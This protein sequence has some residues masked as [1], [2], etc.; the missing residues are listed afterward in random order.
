MVTPR[1]NVG[2][3][4]GNFEAKS[5]FSGEC[6]CLPASADVETGLMHVRI[7]LLISHCERGLHV[8]RPSNEGP[9]RGLFVD[10]G[11]PRVRSSTTLPFFPLDVIGSEFNLP[12]GQVRSHVII[13][14][15]YRRRRLYRK[16]RNGRDGRLAAT[17]S[18]AAAAAAPPPPT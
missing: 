7:L 18:F 16:R 6:E 14:G 15:H 5:R 3:H 2:F 10:L 11:F 13:L 1:L 8:S 9:E 4:T 12:R 17:D